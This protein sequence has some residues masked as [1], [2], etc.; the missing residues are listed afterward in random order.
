ML[1]DAALD[2]CPENL[3]IARNVHRAAALSNGSQ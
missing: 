1:G 3:D 2:K